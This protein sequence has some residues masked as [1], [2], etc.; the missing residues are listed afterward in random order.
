MRASLR[1][2][3][4]EVDAVD[5]GKEDKPFVVEPLKDPVPGREQSPAP[6]PLPDVPPM[7]A[8]APDRELVPA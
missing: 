4:R 6:E 3:A 2:D 1:L 5:I 8:P 7:P